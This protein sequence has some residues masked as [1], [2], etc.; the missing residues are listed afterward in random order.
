ML[1]EAYVLQWNVTSCWYNSN[2]K[3]YSYCSGIRADFLENE[4][5]LSGSDEN[6]DDDM[7]RSDDDDME[8]EEGDMEHFDSNELRNQVRSGIIA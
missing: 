7:E 1:G 8:E 6:S 5:E 2:F 4:A 3:L